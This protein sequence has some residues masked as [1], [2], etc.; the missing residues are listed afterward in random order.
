[1]RVDFKRHHFQN[2]ND[3]RCPCGFHR[4]TKTHLLLNCPIAAPARG[5]MIRAL[6]ELD[7]FN[8][9]VYYGKNQEQKLN[10][11]LYGDRSLSDTLNKKIMTI[12]AI[13]IGSILD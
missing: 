1:M 4:E 6:L 7:D 10:L 13:Y 8:I 3:V 9:M 11:I 12:F 2:Y 5:D